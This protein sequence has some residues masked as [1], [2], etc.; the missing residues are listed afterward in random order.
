MD[1][2]KRPELY[3]IRVFDF[4]REGPGRYVDNLSS[5]FEC[6]P[7]ESARRVAEEIAKLPSYHFA[8]VCDAVSY[9]GVSVGH[10]GGSPEMGPA[11]GEQTLDSTP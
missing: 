1:T 4:E 5:E 8:V 2:G 11:E 7:G 9:A 3:R 10:E 6:L